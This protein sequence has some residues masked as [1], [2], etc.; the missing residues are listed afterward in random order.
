V[1]VAHPRVA[2]DRAD[3]RLG[4]AL[5]EKPQRVGLEDRV[6]VDGDGDVV[7]AGGQGAVERGGLARVDLA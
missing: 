1:A 5:H 6:G 4:E 3:V 2:R 7:L